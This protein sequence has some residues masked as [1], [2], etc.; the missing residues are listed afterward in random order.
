IGS[1][2]VGQGLDSLVF[3]GL[4]FVGTMPADVLA[5]TMATQWTFKVAYEVAATPLTY[6]IVGYLKRQEHIDTYDYTTDLNPLAVG[7]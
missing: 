5:V 2:L 3:I 1:T 4:A 6:L 7:R